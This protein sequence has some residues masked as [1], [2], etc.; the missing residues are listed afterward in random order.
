MY[1][2]Y[3]KQQMYADWFQS[4]KSIL[5][6]IQ[7]LLVLFIVIIA[8]TDYKSSKHCYIETQ[9]K[10]IRINFAYKWTIFYSDGIFSENPVSSKFF[11]GT[12]W[13]VLWFTVC[14]HCFGTHKHLMTRQIYSFD[15]D[16]DQLNESLENLWKSSV[17]CFVC[18]NLRKSSTIHMNA[19]WTFSQIF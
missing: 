19:N 17:D 3:F 4:R 16:D 2:H 1:I 7:L 10:L 12:V 18:V 9:S 5:M 11:V 14:C 13:T 6:L 8:A 15:T